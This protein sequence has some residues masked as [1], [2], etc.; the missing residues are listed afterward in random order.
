MRRAALALL[1][2]ALLLPVAHAHAAAKPKPQV[3]DAGGDSLATKSQD[4]RSVEFKVRGSGS[5]KA[6]VV[7][8]T[9]WSDVMQQVSL[10]NFEVDA[11]ASCGDVSFSMSPGT[12]YEA[13][14]G[15]NGWYSTSCG[16]D[17]QELAAVQVSGPTITWTMP[18]GK[19]FKKGTVFT[20]FEARIDPAQ[21]ALPFPSS[22]TATTLGLVDSATAKGPWRLP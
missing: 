5:A 6:L 9:T 19:A 1:A 4:I 17:V 7:T 8:M 18:L 21:P 14:T 20:D 2:P 10:F 13:V 12:P 22:A 16:G 15:L 3:S 11:K